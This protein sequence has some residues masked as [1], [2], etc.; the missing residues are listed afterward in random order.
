MKKPN[1][2]TNTDEELIKTLADKR[3]EVRAFRFSTAGSA[4]RDVKALHT[5]K[6]DVARILTE[7]NARARNTSAQTP[8]H[9]S[10]QNA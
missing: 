5:N 8:V 3:E 7:R 2:K 1:F 4:A 10:A 6:K 9:T